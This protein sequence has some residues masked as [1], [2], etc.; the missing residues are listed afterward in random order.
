[1]LSRTKLY[2]RGERGDL[3]QSYVF[4]ADIIS[5]KQKASE[6]RFFV[7]SSRVIGYSALIKG[8]RKHIASLVKDLLK[9]RK[10]RKRFWVNEWYDPEYEA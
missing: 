5:L 1:M 3:P 10:L 6:I 8:E 7:S 4:V 2:L 9:R